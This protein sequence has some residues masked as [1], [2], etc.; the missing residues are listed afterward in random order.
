M[1]IAWE[2]KWCP[3]ESQ[4][5]AKNFMIKE[6]GR[7]DRDKSPHECFCVIFFTGYIK[8]KPQVS[9]FIHPL[10]KVSECCG[11]R[12]VNVESDNVRL[13]PSHSLNSIRVVQRMKSIKPLRRAWIG[14]ALC[15]LNGCVET[16]RASWEGIWWR[17]Q[18]WGPPAAPAL[19][20]L[21]L[22][23]SGWLAS[24]QTSPAWKSASG[25]PSPPGPDAPKVITG[26]LCMSVY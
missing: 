1:F 11:E 8:Y 22:A 7:A 4:I 17:L 5:Y 9:R 24:F 2:C 12:S 14:S 18:V 15:E 25:T 10:N 21:L 13:R 19:S 6:T 26:V 16:D 23:S 20:V 3:E